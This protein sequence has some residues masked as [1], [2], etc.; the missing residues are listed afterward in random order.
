M[1]KNQTIM[2]SMY[3]TPHKEVEITALGKTVT[4]YLVER[5][6]HQDSSSSYDS[7]DG[8]DVRPSTDNPTTK[9]TRTPKGEQ[10]EPGQSGSDSQE[11]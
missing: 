11:A 10:E 1:N 7:E 2:D 5:I 3:F 8:Y 9:T 6:M 4:S